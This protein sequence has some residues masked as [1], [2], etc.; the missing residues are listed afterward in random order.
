M[1]GDWAPTDEEVGVEFVVGARVVPEG[2]GVA[3]SS[4]GAEHAA[5]TSSKA[6]QGAFLSLPFIGGWVLLLWDQCKTYWI[7]MAIQRAKRRGSTLPR[8]HRSGGILL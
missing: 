7:R 8:F 1:V 5:T 3:T 6:D 4:A 2:W